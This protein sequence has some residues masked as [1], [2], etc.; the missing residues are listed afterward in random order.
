MLI[1]RLGGHC[2]LHI[3]AVTGDDE[4]EYSCEARNEHGVASTAQQLLVNCTSLCSMQ[5]YLCSIT[6]S[7]CF[8][9]CICVFACGMSNDEFIGFRRVHIY[10]GSGSVWFI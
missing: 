4:A 8:A 3:H 5:P 6:V 9:D 7:L 2:S 10:T 1:E